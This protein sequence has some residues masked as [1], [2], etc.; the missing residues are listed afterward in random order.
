MVAV[1]RKPRAWASRCTSS[2]LA[3]RPF[4]W[5]IFS[6]DALGEN[7]G[8]S[9]GKRGLPGLL[10]PSEHF[11]NLQAGDRRH[12]LNLHRRPEVGRDSGK[13]RDDG[14]YHV[15]VVVEGQL[16]VDPALHQHRGHALRHRALDLR[17]HLVD[18]MGVGLF[19]SWRTVEGA[20]GAVDVAHVGVV[21]IGVDDERH[22]RIGMATPADDHGE[23]PQVRDRGL[24][25]KEQ[26]VLAV[27]ALLMEYLVMD[28]V[29]ASVVGGLSSHD[30]LFK[31]ASGDRARARVVETPRGRASLRPRGGN[32]SCV[33]KTRARR[34]CR[35]FLRAP[36][37]SLRCS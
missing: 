14:A 36:P 26:S 1:E 25:Q 34:Q 32:G 2:Q 27:E 8:A 12:S 15:Q 24:T 16:G 23:L 3:A 35:S 4:L 19:V 11:P 22:G 17:E 7:L 33:D 20:E 13:A 6:P 10:E 30:H 18:G 37:R 5:E 28:V 21:R 29:D 31:S 9:A